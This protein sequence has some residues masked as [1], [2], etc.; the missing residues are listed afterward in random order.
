MIVELRGTL[1]QRQGGYCV[2][3]VNGVGYGI[4]ISRDTE[5][6]LGDIGES[7]H[8]YTHLIVR[9]D[10]W[11]LVGFNTSQERQCFVDMLSV[12]GVGVKGALALLNHLGL[13]GV[14]SSVQDGRWQKLKEAPGVGAKIAQRAVLELSGK[15]KGPGGEDAITGTSLPPVQDSYSDEALTALISLGFSVAEASDALKGL[16]VDQTVD[17]RL[18]LALQRL[19]A[20][21]GVRS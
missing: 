16:A 2:V 21:K 13:E 7:V 15:W 14:V 5:N 10:G 8:L 11:R 20:H 6:S 19:D 17:T 1:A 18:R 3:D 9:E 12:N 4:E